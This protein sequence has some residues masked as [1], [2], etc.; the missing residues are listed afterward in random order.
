M[1]LNIHTDPQFEKRLDWLSRRL[2]KTK[3]DVIKELVFEKYHLKKSGFRFGSLK[4]AK[5]VPSKKL[6]EELKALDR[7]RDLD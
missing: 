1:A 6:Q 4:D 3:T 5:K 7:D 2:K